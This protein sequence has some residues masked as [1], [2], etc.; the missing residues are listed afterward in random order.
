VEA[1]KSQNK[2]KAYLLCSENEGAPVYTP[3][4]PAFPAFWAVLNW[5]MWVGGR[6]VMRRPMPPTP[7][8]PF[9]PPSP[10]N[11]QFSSFQLSSSL[12]WS[13]PPAAAQNDNGI[14]FFIFHFSI[15][16]KSQIRLYHGF[17]AP[18]PTQITRNI[19]FA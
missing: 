5:A 12:A 14:S 4:P 15:F 17:A 8:L 1:G 16:P 2:I 9:I 13:C 10:K 3:P 19:N 18:Y 11:R 6:I 7:W